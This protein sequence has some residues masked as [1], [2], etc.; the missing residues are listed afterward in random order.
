MESK[1]K[2]TN[3]KKFKVVLYSYKQ[4]FHEFFNVF[5]I[6]IHRVMF[7]LIVLCLVHFP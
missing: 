5:F 2:N 6:I 7:F 3:E 1:N 4:C